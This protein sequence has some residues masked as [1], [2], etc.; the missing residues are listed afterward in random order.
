[1]F[2]S[3][4]PRKSS[5]ELLFPDATIDHQNTI[6]YLNVLLGLPDSEENI[7]FGGRILCWNGFVK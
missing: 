1:M 3:L 5:F 7:A 4:A 6:N 2:K